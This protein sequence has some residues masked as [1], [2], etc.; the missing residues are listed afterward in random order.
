MER[1]KKC[2]KENSDNLPDSGNPHGPVLY[3]AR[4]GEE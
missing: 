2:G 3:T 1:L 4:T